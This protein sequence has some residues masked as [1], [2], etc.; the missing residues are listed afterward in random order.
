MKKYRA[1]F[2]VFIVLIVFCVVTSM[3]IRNHRETIQSQEKEISVL[4]L[5]IIGYENGV[6]VEAN[7]NDIVGGSL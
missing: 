5:T 3:V 4:E 6:H 7:Y 1:F 2:Y